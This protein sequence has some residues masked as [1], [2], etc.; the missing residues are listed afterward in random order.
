MRFLAIVSLLKLF[1]LPLS[2]SDKGAFSYV[3]SSSAVDPVYGVRL[4]S[5]VPAVDL[6]LQYINN[7]SSLLP[8]INLTYGEVSTLQVYCSLTNYH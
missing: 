5:T 3:L 6:A 2:R 8:A 7:N 1:M 4:D